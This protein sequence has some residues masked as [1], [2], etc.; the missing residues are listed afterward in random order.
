MNFSKCEITQN[1]ETVKIDINGQKISFDKD[2]YKEYAVFTKKVKAEIN[3][4]TLFIVLLLL[5]IIWINISSYFGY[6]RDTLPPD[7]LK[8]WKI[9]DFS[10]MIGLTLLTLSSFLLDIMGGFKFVRSLVGIP[11]NRTKLFL[12]VI[13]TNKNEY[14]IPVKNKREAIN[15]VNAFQLEKNRTESF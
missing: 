9:T 13:L 10:I 12:I 14:S 8:I 6:L 7:K 5:L 2:L 4:W 15:I 1:N 3:R 11:F